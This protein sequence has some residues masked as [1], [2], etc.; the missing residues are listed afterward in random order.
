MAFEDAVQ[1]LHEAVHT[2]LANADALLDGEAV[3]VVFDNTYDVALGAAGV[4][5]PRAALPS[6]SAVGVVPETSTLEIVGG[7]TYTVEAVLPDGAGWTE[8][9]L[10][11]AA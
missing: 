1:R 6:A 7:S 8:M 3:R 11:L 2:R 9:H 10:R 5:R 4:R